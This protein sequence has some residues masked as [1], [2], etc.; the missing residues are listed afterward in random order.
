M[1]RLL[2]ELD[3]RGF[4][5]SS[6]PLPEFRRADSKVVLRRLT[7]TV[8]G[9]RRA[10]TLPRGPN[11]DAADRFNRQALAVQAMFNEIVDFR[12]DVGSRDPDY[13]Y[14]VARALFGPLDAPQD[15]E[16]R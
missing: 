14:D 2:E 6:A 4:V 7:V 16:R 1:D 12:Q 5:E 8:G 11:R 13:F 10:F 15:G 9:Q 3:E